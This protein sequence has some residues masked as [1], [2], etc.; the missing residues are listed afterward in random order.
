LIFY[1]KGGDYMKK[2]A[3][4]TTAALLTFFVAQSAMAQT[5]TSTPSPSPTSATT[6]TPTVAV[7]SGAPATG[8]GGV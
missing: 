1:L 8:H 6:T 2:I 7:P 5:A 3:I 4:G